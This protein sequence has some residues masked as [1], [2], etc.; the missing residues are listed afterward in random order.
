VSLFLHGHYAGIDPS[1]GSGMNAM[2]LKTK[3][4]VKEILNYAGSDLEQKLGK[5]DPSHLVQGTISKYFQARYGFKPLCSIVTAAGDNPCTLVGLKLGLGD[6]AVSLG[7]SSTVFGPLINP[8]PSADEG[9]IMC[10][11]VD[12]N[13]YMG[14]IC[15]KNGALAR[16][17]VRDQYANKSWETF[18]SY[19]RETPPGNNGNIGFYFEE[20]EIIPPVKGF[21]FFDASDKPTG[22][23]TD[24]KAHVRGIVESQT[25]SKYVHAENIGLKVTHGILVTGGTSKN[26]EILQ[27]LSDVFG[28]PV[29]TGQ[30]P[31]SASLGAAYRAL[32]AIKCQEAGKFVPFEAVVGG[33]SFQKSAQPNLHNHALYKTLSKRYKALE[34]KIVHHTPARL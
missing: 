9:N 26:V 32:H 4:W 29:Y 24:N 7:T 28:V 18:S 30:Q 22:P 23:W 21:Y 15:Y 5:V 2:N 12:I 13:G 16:E 33:T 6:I 10:N 31:N 11:P 27:V 1:D 25:L 8:V 34:E 17:H 20:D 3:T 14:M 19:L